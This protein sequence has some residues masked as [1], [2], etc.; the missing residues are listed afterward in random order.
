MDYDYYFLRIWSK[1]HFCVSIIIKNME[2][3]VIQT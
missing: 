3:K 2:N 1:E